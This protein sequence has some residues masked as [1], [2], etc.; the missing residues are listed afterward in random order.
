[1]YI[2]ICAL[3]YCKRVKGTRDVNFYVIALRIFSVVSLGFTDNT[4]Y[5]LFVALHLDIGIGY[6]YI[7]QILILDIGIGMI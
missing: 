7:C 1:M 6:A 4:H 3:T 2:H 5:L